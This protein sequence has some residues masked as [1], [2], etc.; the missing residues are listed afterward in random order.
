MRSPLSRRSVAP[1]FII[2]APRSG[3]TWLQKA[4]NAHPAVYCTEHRLFG[5]HMDLV[6]D[7]DAPSPRLRI[8]LDQYVKSSLQSATLDN[9]AIS[10]EDFEWELVQT[11]AKT[12]VAQSLRASGKSIHVDKI[13]PYPGTAHHVIA[14]IQAI[15]PEAKVIL[16]LRD[17]RDV[18]TSGVYHWSKK[19]VV[20]PTDTD[21]MTPEQPTNGGFFTDTQITE[22][23]ELWR[24][25]EQ[26]THGVDPQH[27]L[28]VRYEDM[29]TNQPQ[30]LKRILQYLGANASSATLKG[31]VTE[32]SFEAMSGGRQQGEAEQGAHVRKGISGDWKQHFTREVAKRFDAIAGDLLVKLGYETD[33]SWVDTTG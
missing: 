27:L 31:C 3:T 11:L 30:E 33:R 10:A 21:L 2:A 5:P 16:L 18:L 13:T 32:S 12:V 29:L 22:W 26:A 25:V 28:T 20:D 17:G 19:A 24:D 6:R 7:G 14:C 1:T 8:T 9:L 23:A 4:L 15:W